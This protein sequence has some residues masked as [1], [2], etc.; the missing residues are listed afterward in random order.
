[1]DLP[2]P[3]QPVGELRADQSGT[4][5]WFICPGCGE[6]HAPYVEGDE[7]KVPVWW[8]NRSITRPTISPSIRASRDRGD[9]PSKYLC[10]IYVREGKVE[11]LPDCL[12]DNAGKTLDMIP[13]DNRL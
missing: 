10:H 7:K 2:T 4:R 9:A 8:W 6:L 12:H 13:W 3:D 5:F 1:M 11:C